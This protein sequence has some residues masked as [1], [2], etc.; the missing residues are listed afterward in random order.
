MSC[1]IYMVLQCL[2][3]TPSVSHRVQ[4]QIASRLLYSFFRPSILT[5]ARPALAYANHRLPRLNTLVSTSTSDAL[6]SSSLSW[7]SKHSSRQLNDSVSSRKVCICICAT[8]QSRWTLKYTRRIMSCPCNIGLSESHWS[9]PR[10]HNR[11]IHGLHDYQN[12][13]GTWRVEWQVH[14][15]GIRLSFLGIWLYSDVNDCLRSQRVIALIYR[16][17]PTFFTLMRH[18]DVS[19]FWFMFWVT[20]QVYTSPT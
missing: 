5:A 3:H 19:H 8:P 20:Q 4:L 7:A 12:V 11:Q 13:E 18:P 2:G 1:I 6:S 14:I 15:E 10:R 9:P 16:L 17:R